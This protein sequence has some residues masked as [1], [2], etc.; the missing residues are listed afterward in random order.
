MICVYANLFDILVTNCNND[1]LLK[2]HSIIQFI[3]DLLVKKRF[4]FNY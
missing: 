3:E 1:I 4:Y 2:M